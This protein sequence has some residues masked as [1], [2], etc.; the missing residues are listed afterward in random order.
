LSSVLRALQKLEQETYAATGMPGGS[1]G[2]TGHGFALHVNPVRRHRLLAALF[3]L[4]LALTGLGA[5]V[6]G[7]AW[8]FPAGSFAPADDRRA[9]HVPRPG[10][11]AI[12]S[13]PPQMTAEPESPGL[14]IAAVRPEHMDT[15]GRVRHEAPRHSGDPASQPAPVTLMQ[16]VVSPWPGPAPVPDDAVDGAA[17]GSESNQQ[18]RGD[19]PIPADNPEDGATWRAINKDTVLPVEPGP[20]PEAVSSP[21]SVSV[22]KPDSSRSSAVVSKPAASEFPELD[23]S[24]GLTLQAISWSPDPARRLA[25]IN[26]RLCREGESVDG[27]ALVR[28]NPDE[29][30]L[31]DGRISGRLVFKVR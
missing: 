9:S 14:D 15:E 28:I 23:P 7:K 2:K 30:L 4:L 26:G 21:E 10:H 17:A 22:P 25:V 16:D 18:E 8:L 13:V 5:I 24:A 29:I 20:E 27:Y 19:A 31:S 12:H 1:G 6:A 3:I 11:P